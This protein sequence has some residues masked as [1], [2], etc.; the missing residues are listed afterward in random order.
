MIDL[1]L[2][3]LLVLSGALAFV[4]LL[5]QAIIRMPGDDWWR[6]DNHGKK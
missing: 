2:N 3:Q 5:V 1:T 6:R 4:I